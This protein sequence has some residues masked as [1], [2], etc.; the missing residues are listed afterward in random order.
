MTA[1][2]LVFLLCLAEIA[3]MLGFA[4]FPALLP[5]FLSDWRL[6]AGEAGWLSGVFF[7][8]Y[9]GAVPVL[10]A[11]T[12]RFDARRIFLC[13]SLL[14]GL[15]SLLF[16]LL[17]Q[18]FWSAVPLRL[19]AGAG[20]AGT[21]MPGLKALTDRLAPA[22]QPR[23][24]SFYTS[25]FG[26][27]ASASY[28]LSGEVAA[29]ADWRWAFAL[30]GLGGLAAFAIVAAALRPLPPTAPASA[31]RVLDFR[32]VLRN[33]EA[34]GYVL[35]Y[36]AHNWELFGLRSWIVAF[37]V[38][39][40]SQ[41]QAETAGFWSATAIAALLNLLGTPASILG[42]EAATRFGRRRMAACFQLVS[43]GFAGCV[44]LSVGIAYPM[45]IGLLGLYAMLLMSESAAVTTGAVQ[46]A[47]PERKGATMA[48]HSTL[49]FALAFLGSLAP[50]LV[51]DAAGGTG[52]AVAWSLAFLSMGAGVALG[53]LALWLTRP[54]G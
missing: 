18:D 30:A 32:P 33:R 46:A 29:L 6:S 36:A 10:T 5:I 41:A 34:M 24:V 49:G 12:D 27:G 35:A 17:A 53:P 43:A 21:Y 31:W 20:L 3:S 52:S 7:A 2:R 39:A 13:G 25:S 51:L 4:V 50:G 22:A 44:A 15:A 42:N 54:R 28:F 19:L 9:M 37:L 48:L 26:L 8:G 1:G 11:L 14:S 45:L 40:A 47:R 38:F 23:A 16:A